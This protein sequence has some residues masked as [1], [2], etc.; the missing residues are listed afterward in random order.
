MK[1]DQQVGDLLGL[2]YSLVYRFN[3]EQYPLEPG[4]RHAVLNVAY[5]VFYLD[6]TVVG[7]DELCSE[8]FEITADNLQA[9]IDEIMP[10]IKFWG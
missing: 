1:H 6:F 8:P 4:K 10:M 9:K 7:Q 2:L 3:C 5:N